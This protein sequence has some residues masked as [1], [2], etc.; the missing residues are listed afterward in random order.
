[1]AI[2]IEF[3][4][5]ADESRPEPSNDRSGA[6]GHVVLTLTALVALFL[7]VGGCGEGATEPEREEAAEPALTTAHLTSIYTDQAQTELGDVS[8][9]VG[10]ASDQQV[11]QTITQG[12]TGRPWLVVAAVGCQPGSTLYAE[13]WHVKGDAPAKP[14]H[15]TTL[16]SGITGPATWRKLY[17]NT[18]PP[19][20]AGR[21]FALVLRAEGQCGWHAG[22]PESYPGGIG[23]ARYSGIA[24]QPLSVFGTGVRDMT[25]VTYVR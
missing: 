12:R 7:I 24:W 4:P 2:F 8:M 13:L 10:G 18:P 11:A 19:I 15:T 14:F 3:N 9:L 17:L 23:T 25:F 16:T 1:M 22:P 6:I 20:P 5:P 21:R